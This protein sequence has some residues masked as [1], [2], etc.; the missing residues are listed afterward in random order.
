MT[1][2]IDAAILAR[3]PDV[4]PMR[5][6]PHLYGNTLIQALLGVKPVYRRALR[7]L[8]SFAQSLHDLTFPSLP[9]P[10]YTMLCRQGKRL[11]SNY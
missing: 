1:L 8:Q 3:T 4:I 5:G 11:A 7:A 9:V 2:W 10:N 6:R